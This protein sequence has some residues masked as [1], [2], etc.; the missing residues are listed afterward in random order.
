MR[1]GSQTTNHRAPRRPNDGCQL[2]RLRLCANAR[3]RHRQKTQLKKEKF[4]PSRIRIEGVFTSSTKNVNLLQKNSSNIP[5]ICRIQPY[6][7]GKNITDKYNDGQQVGNKVFPKKGY[8]THTMERMRLR[9]T[10][11]FSHH[12]RSRDTKQSR[13]FLIKN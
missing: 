5:C 13:S 12:A 3:R 11:Q 7:V 4:R 10:I 9:T 1:I 8:S 6:F 2:S